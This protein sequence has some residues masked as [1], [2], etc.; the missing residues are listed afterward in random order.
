MIPGAM[1]SYPHRSRSIFLLYAG[2]LLAGGV[3]S[4]CAPS[5]VAESVDSSVVLS[6]VI[7]HDFGIVNLETNGG[8]VQHTFVLKNSTDATIR[9]INKSSTC[10]CTDVEIDRKDITAGQSLAITSTLNLSDS[11]P[12]VAQVTLLTDSAV[13]PSIVLTLKATGRWTRNLTST[14]QH[15]D[16]ERDK[17]AIISLFAIDYL[18]DKTLPPPIVSAPDGLSV[19]FLV[20]GLSSKDATLPSAFPLVGRE[21]LSSQL[22]IQQLR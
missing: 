9:I 6:G 10:G 1:T 7:V 13:Q 20:S 17:A 14:R 8:R 19:T 2:F 15:V 12:K 22:A 5:F 18:Q 21:S 3:T 16:I 11:G 4:G